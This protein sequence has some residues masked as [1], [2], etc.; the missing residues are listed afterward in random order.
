MPTD[1]PPSIGKPA[2]RAFANAGLTTVE[3]FAKV[4]EKEIADLHGVGPKA[5]GIIRDLLAAQGRTF[6]DN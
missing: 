1:L 3:D 6:A 5:I 2:T 4:T